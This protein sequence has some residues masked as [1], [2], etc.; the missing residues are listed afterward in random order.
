MLETIRETTISRMTKVTWHPKF[1]THVNNRASQSDVRIR[2]K[3]HPPQ[4][5]TFFSFFY[6]PINKMF[7]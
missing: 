4:R 1:F 5:T 3:C 7:I 6:I 2:C